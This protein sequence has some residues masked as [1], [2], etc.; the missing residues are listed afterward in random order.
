VRADCTRVVLLMELTNFANSMHR[1]IC[2]RRFFHCLA[3]VPGLVQQEDV[4]V[5]VGGADVAVLDVQMLKDV[6]CQYDDVY[7]AR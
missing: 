4:V 2:A 5:Q 6:K 3:G 7:Q 1:L